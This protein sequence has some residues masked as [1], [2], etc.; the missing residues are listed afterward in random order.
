MGV[1][2]IT[3]S[4]KRAWLTAAASLIFIGSEGKFALAGFVLCF[5]AAYFSGISI[6]NTRGK[7]E[8]TNFRKRL[9]TAN[10][11]LDT[12]AAVYF[13]FTDTDRIGQGGM[14]FVKP[15]WAVIPLHLISYL[16]DVYRCSCGAQTRALVLMSYAGFFPSIGTGLVLRYNSFEKTFDAPKPTRE[17]FAAGV[18]TYIYG[19]AA[20][21][22]IGRRLENVWANIVQTDAQIRGGIA[23]WLAA[24][25]YFAMFVVSVTGLIHIGQGVALMLGFFMKPAFAMRFS[26]SSIYDWICDFNRPFDLWIKDYVLSPCEKKV[27]NKY[28]A[29]TAAVCLG[30]FWYGLHYSW[31]IV[32]IAISGFIACQGYLHSV[33][34]KSNRTYD[35]IATKI[36]FAFAA[37]IC[38]FS[39]LARYG[40]PALISTA[41]TDTHEKYLAYFISEAWLPALLGFVVSGSLVSAMFRRLERSRLR[42]IISIFELLLYIVCIAY[43]IY[44]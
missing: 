26:E 40:T 14:S 9:L 13:I 33:R 18:R 20:Y 25:V 17:K 44:G 15:A 5:L 4:K 8:K 34:K 21:L 31:L 41:D 43:A 1:Y 30:A 22:I 11:L 2:L 19:L 24:A 6:Y 28:F 38:S 27:S 36:L 39:T 35:I 23:V 3:P 42:F 16:V 7:P 29:L 32:G 10:I 37:L 12:A